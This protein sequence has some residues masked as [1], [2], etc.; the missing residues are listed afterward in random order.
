MIVI[1]TVAFNEKMK[2]K[3]KSQ[4]LNHTQE[5]YQFS[6]IIINSDNNDNEWIFDRQ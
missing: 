4:Q 1:M 2:T 5:Q 3:Q 6:L